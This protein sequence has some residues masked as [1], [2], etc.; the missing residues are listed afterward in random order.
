M[1]AE[2]LSG[3]LSSQKKSALVDFLKELPLVDSDF[4]HWARVGDLRRK[5][6]AKG[7]SVST[8]DAHV[9]QSCLDINARLI[10][11]DKVFYEL[12]KF[13]PNLRIG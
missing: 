12:A 2:L 8:P 1:V 13:I 3:N 9:A 10:T 7:R 4:D 5:A 11:E 6:A